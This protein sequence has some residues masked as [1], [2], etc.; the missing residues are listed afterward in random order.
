[1][2]I[3]SLYIHA[4]GGLKNLTLDFSDNFNV[5]YGDNEMGKTTVMTFIC[6]KRV[7]FEE[8]MNSMLN[9]AILFYG[10]VYE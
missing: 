10:I 2:K 4:F 9:V 1:M 8:F 6:L 5:I 3:N 7:T